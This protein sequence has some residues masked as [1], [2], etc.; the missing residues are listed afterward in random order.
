MSLKM[1]AGLGNPG[2]RYRRTRH[3]LG[4]RVVDELAD[5]AGIK[6]KKKNKLSARIGQGVDGGVPLLLVKPQTFVNASGPAVARV[7][8]YF[9][10]ELSGLLVV[11]DD[12]DLPPG[13]IR[14]RRRGGAGGHR[15]LR[16]IIEALGSDD[17][18]RLRLGIGGAHLSDLTGHVLGRPGDDEENQCSRA[19]AAAAAAV[20]FIFRDGIE[21]AMNR[22]NR[23]VKET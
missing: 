22:Y 8:S 14:I 7:M 19:I 2:R 4:F 15:G 21:A 10:V 1:V 17:F 12:V 20:K 18:A 13:A 6:L 5:G 9:Q 16:S 11:T 3:N 23:T